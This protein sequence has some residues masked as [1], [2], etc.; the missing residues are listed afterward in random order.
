MVLP[1]RAGTFLIS[2][3]ATSFMESAVSRM[4]WISSASRSR[5]VNKSFRF[6]A[7]S[8]SLGCQQSA[9]SRQQGFQGQPTADCYLLD[10]I[11]DHHTVHPILLLENHLALTG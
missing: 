6:S 9:I 2:R 8:P 3:E 1:R 5:I 11:E 10:V 4:N 7:M